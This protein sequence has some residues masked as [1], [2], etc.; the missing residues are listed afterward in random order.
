MIDL[1]GSSGYTR[2]SMPHYLMMNGPSYTEKCYF[3][4]IS[5]RSAEAK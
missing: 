4:L 1:L 3:E 2:Y 5:F